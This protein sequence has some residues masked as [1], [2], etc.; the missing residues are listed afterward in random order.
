M[1]APIH[2]ATILLPRQGKKLLFLKRCSPDEYL[3]IF[4]GPEGETAAGV[5]AATAAEAIRLAATKW[6]HN[7]FRTINCG[8]RFTL[9]ERD[10]HGAP[11]LFSQMA[12]SYLSPN[13]VY[14]DEDY[15]TCIVTHASK[16]ALFLLKTVCQAAS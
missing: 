6:K 2:A 5:S 14:Q 10:E 15:G 8:K 16:E 7:S 3:W 12:A 1:N 4:L 11:A 13:G 9:P